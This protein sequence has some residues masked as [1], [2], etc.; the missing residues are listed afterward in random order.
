MPDSIINSGSI[1]FLG[2]GE[3]AR[4]FLAG[5]RANPDFRARICAYDI[6]TDSPDTGVRTAKRGDYSAASVLGA[7]SAAEA[8]T[9]AEA[10]FSVV[11]ADQAH[12]AALAA[13]PGLAKG[14][15]FSTAI[16]ARRKPSRAPRTRSR[17]RAG[18][19][20]TSR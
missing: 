16:P 19:M 4:A 17:P 6:K 3:A 5:W 8:V 12:E 11:T 15:V 7:S 13:L 10:V 9:G 1:A 18:A 2:F 14:A 20:S